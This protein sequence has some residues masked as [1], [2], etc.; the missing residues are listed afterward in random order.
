MIYCT[1]IY[2]DKLKS[3]DGPEIGSKTYLYK[4]QRKSSGKR[5]EKEHIMEQNAGGEM[6]KYSRQQQTKIHRKRYQQSKA[7]QD[8]QLYT[9]SIE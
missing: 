9:H 6:Q 5:Q 2:Y 4:R 8:Q 7:E 3:K 1:L